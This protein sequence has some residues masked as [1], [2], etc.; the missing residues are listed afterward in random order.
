[1]PLQTSRHYA[2]VCAFY[3]DCEARARRKRRFGLIKHYRKQYKKYRGLLYRS[4]YEKNP[5]GLGAC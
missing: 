4:V 2:S 5:T 3:L 1:M